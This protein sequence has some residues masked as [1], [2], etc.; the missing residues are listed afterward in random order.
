[1]QSVVAG[2]V[3]FGVA[4][5]LPA[6]LAGW[7]VGGIAGASSGAASYGAGCALGSACSWT[8]LAEST[9]LGGVLGAALGAVVGGSSEDLQAQAEAAQTRAD[10]IH[11]WHM[12]R[13]STYPSTED[14]IAFKQRMVAV[15]KTDAEDVAGGG[16]R[17]LS[18]GQGLVPKAVGVSF[19][20]CD[21]CELFIQ[22][23]GG[24][25]T[26]PKTAVWPQFGSAPADPE[27][28]KD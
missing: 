17:D 13:P 28:Y 5:A 19:D 16:Q 12:N 6:G 2:G 4:A 23:T 7:A 9:A 22:E 15:V 8:G 21:L 18:P 3:A 1:M 20:F 11:G 10:D 27:Y 25:I 14:P 26:S 24:I